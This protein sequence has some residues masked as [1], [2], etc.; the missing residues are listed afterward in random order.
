MAIDAIAE[1]AIDFTK[2]SGVT[3]PM[4]LDTRNVLNRVL[5]VRTVTNAFL[6]DEEGIL[7]WQHL[8]GFR[9]ARPEMLRMVERAISG[10]LEEIWADPNV[11]QESLD[12]EVLRGELATDPNNPEYTFMLAEALCQEDQ[13]DEGKQLYHR[14]IE[15][16]PA[17]SAAYYALGSLYAEEGNKNEAVRVMRQGLERDPMN[18]T[19]RKQIWRLEYPEKFYPKI[20]M[21]FQVERIK[22]EGFPDLSKLPISIRRELELE[23]LEERTAAGD[24]GAAPP[25]DS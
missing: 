17:N 15:L 4:A 7:R 19:I 23:D 14:V 24:A 12:I 9:I 18:F 13:T 2:S 5:G 3:F 16:D 6:L 8:H 22:E 21:A 20:D 10:D 1:H 25:V 11:R